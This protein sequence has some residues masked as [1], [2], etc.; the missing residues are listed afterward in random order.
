MSVIEKDQSVFPDFNIRIIRLGYTGDIFLV[1]CLHF[2]LG[3]VSLKNVL[4]SNGKGGAEENPEFCCGEH[5][6]STAVQVCKLCKLPC[7]FVLW[8]KSQ[9]HNI[10]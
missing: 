7:W 8:T 1:Y 9:I 2:E 5:I 4:F 6:E 10:L 3:T